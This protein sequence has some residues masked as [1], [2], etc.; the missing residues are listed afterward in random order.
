MYCSGVSAIRSVKSV[1]VKTLAVNREER[2][3]PIRV[4]TGTPI[5]SDSQAVV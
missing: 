1:A 2:R 4:T 3:S 5:Q